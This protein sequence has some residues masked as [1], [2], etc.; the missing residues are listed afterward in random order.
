MRNVGGKALDGVDAVVKIAGHGAQAVG[1]VADF[2]GAFGEVGD[3]AA[4]AR[5]RTHPVR[6]RR[7]PFHR[8]GDGARQ[9]EGRDQHHQKGHQHHFE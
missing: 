9:I 5:A 2:V 6:R 8:F 4:P 1:Q 7:Q 3:V